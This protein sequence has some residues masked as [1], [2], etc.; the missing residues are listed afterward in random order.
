MTAETSP[1]LAYA[2]NAYSQNGEDGIIERI[3]ELIG[4]TDGWCVEFGAWD[5][6]HLSNCANLVRNRGYHAVLIEANPRKAEELTANYLDYP[7]VT[8]LAGFVG[9]GANDNLDALLEPAPIPPDFD[10]LSIDIDGNDYH[11]WNAVTRHRPKI[12]VI[13]FNPTIHLDVDWA[14]PPTRTEWAAPA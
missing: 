2:R 9:W 11:V 1:L 4:D 3:L 8:T 12:V 6:L 5:G 10:L 13:E 7:N 14:R